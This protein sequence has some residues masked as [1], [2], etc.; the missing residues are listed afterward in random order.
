MNERTRLDSIIMRLVDHRDNRKKRYTRRL[1]DFLYHKKDLFFER[2][3]SLFKSMREFSFK[4]DKKRKLS[5]FSLGK[6]ERLSSKR[7]SDSL[8]D[9]VMVIR[10]Y[11]FSLARSLLQLLI[12]HLEF[13]NRRICLFKFCFVFYSSHSLG[14]V[15]FWLNTRRYFGRCSQLIWTTWLNSKLAIVGIVFLYFNCSTTISEIIVST[16][17]YCLLIFSMD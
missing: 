15:S 1:L 4:D 14:F 3:I 12:M 2:L 5:E 17:F 6:I 11:I 13:S 10:F 7:G 16:R 9:L 8:G